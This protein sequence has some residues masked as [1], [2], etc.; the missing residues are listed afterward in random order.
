M[1]SP[2]NTPSLR[3]TYDLLHNL[4]PPSPLPGSVLV[5]D[6]EVESSNGSSINGD[7]ESSNGGLSLTTEIATTNDDI[8]A[9]LKLV[10]ESVTQQRGMAARAIVLHPLSVSMFTVAISALMHFMLKPGLY[11][12]LVLTATGLVILS[13]AFVRQVT[14]GY[15]VAA[16]DF[17]KMWLVDDQILVSKLG[18]V[19]IG[20]LVY[21][22]E[23]GEGRG[24]RRKKWGKG[25]IR[26]WT[27]K[28][29]YRCK[30]IGTELLEDA[31]RETAKRGGEEVVFA[32]DHASQYTP[33]LCIVLSLM[34]SRLQTPAVRVLSRTFRSQTATV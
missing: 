8:V 11:S 3:P 18:G 10:A 4:P 30:G 9:A 13:C 7:S 31:V 1:P 12:K 16:E 28:Q 29:K 21:G 20:A 24:N 17:S 33:L 26:A 19:V 14:M 2:A 27:V 15:A 6:D 22:W 34:S 25:I 5:V 32:K 23:K